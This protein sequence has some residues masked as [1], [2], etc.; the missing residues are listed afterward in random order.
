[1]RDASGDIR[2]EKV[3][4]NIVAADTAAF[5]CEKIGGSCIAK[6]IKG[7]FSLEK[8]GG[9]MKAQ[10]IEGTMRVEKLGGSFTAKDIFLEGDLHV[11]GDIR[12]INPKF[13]A[14]RAELYAGGDVQL[15]V[16]DEFTDAAFE[17]RSGDEDIRIKLAQDELT[18]NSGHYEYQVGNAASKIEVAAGGSISISSPFD[19]DEEVVGDISNRFQYEESPFSE[20]IRERVES[21]TRIAEA[22]VK[23]AEIRLGQI[24]DRVEKHRGFNINVDFDKTEPEVDFEQPE[25]PVPPVSRPPGKKGATNEERLMILKMLQDKKITVDEAE[26]LFNA[27][28]E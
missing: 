22:K 7:D 14:H 10:W 21:A 8:A 23:T 6:N 16:T 18:I 2:I 20:M 15:E 19:P 26:T 5:K 17:L 27:L 11:G 13:G 3:G 9:S 24:R 25:Q 28:A 1:V 12:L 4:G